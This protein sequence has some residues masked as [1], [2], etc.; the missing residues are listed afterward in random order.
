MLLLV[1]VMLATVDVVI[2]LDMGADIPEMSELVLLLDMFERHTVGAARFTVSVHDI[3]GG[4]EFIIV[5]KE[6]AMGTMLTTKKNN[7][8]TTNKQIIRVLEIIHSSR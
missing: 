5:E 2:L 6:D 8:K 7:K 1:T 4:D 3:I